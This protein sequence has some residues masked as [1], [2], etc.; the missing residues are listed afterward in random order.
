MGG[1]EVAVIHHSGGWVMVEDACPHAN[2]AFTENGEVADGIT[3]VCNC[4]GSEFDLRTGEL[5][6]GPA[7]SPLSLS[8]LL[9]ESGVLRVAAR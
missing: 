7:Q 4:H 8:P 9:V 3:L 5:L 6:L 2:C 1:L